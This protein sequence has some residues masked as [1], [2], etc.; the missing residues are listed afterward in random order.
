M[1]FN[2]F[3]SESLERIADKN[4]ISILEWNE[5][6]QSVGYQSITGKEFSKQLAEMSLRLQLSGL[7]NHKVAILSENSLDLVLIFLTCLSRGAQVCI[8]DYKLTQ[9]EVDAV[10]NDLKPHF[11]FI[12]SKKSNWSSQLNVVQSHVTKAMALN[13]LKNIPI[14]LANH[15]GNSVTPGSQPKIIVYTS[16]TSGVPKGVVLDISTTIFEAMSIKRSFVRDYSDRK[17]FSILPLNHIYGVI[18]IYISLWIDQE[19]IL[20]QSLAPAHIRQIIH[21]KKPDYIS[22]VPQFLSLI[23]NRVLDGI[24]GKPFLV[25]TIAKTFLFIN[26][27][28]G[29]PAIANMFFGE[30]KKQIGPSIQFAISGGATLP[31]SIFNFFEAIGMPICNGYGLTETAPVIATNNIEFR[32]RGSVGKALDGV[33]IRI[34]PENDEIQTKGPHLFDGYYEKPDLTKEAFTSDGW[35]KTGDVGHIDKDGYLF[36]TGRSK[37]MIVL[38]S[39]KKVQPEE[40]E[41]HFS[42]VSFV[43]NC[44]LIYSAGKSKI[45]RMHLIIE[46]ADGVSLEQKETLLKEAQRH[47]E[48]LAIFKRPQ[49]YRL[50]TTPLPL[51]SS[52]KVKRFIVQKELDNES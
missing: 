9:P 29:S 30:I 35:F 28:L 17:N 37:N 24:N 5:H 10:L 50:R 31:R 12:D 21:D 26:Q 13:D 19:L 25:R 23:R 41:D 3:L 46:L 43:K 2:A 47:A 18:M 40:I 48:R 6:A 22:V 15:N 27:Y 14:S 32:R 4:F 1:D 39:G 20:T 7:G 16:G 38:P 45:K 49:E 8:L 33:Q 52:L 36:I 11:L 42:Q 34:A 51:T 44:S